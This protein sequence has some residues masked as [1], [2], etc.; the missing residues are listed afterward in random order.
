MSTGHNYFGV[1]TIILH[2]ITIVNEYFQ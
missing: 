2:I 1:F